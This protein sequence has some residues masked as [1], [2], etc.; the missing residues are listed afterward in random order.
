MTEDQDLLAKISQLAGKSNFISMLGKLLSALQARST[1]T[2]IKLPKAS[3]ETPHIMPH[4]SIEVVGL[5]IVF[6]DP[7]DGK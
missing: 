6:E 7:R 3:T 2:R 4:I 5:H 1:S